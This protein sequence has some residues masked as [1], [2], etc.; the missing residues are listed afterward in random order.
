MAQRWLNLN[1][2]PWGGHHILKG[3]YKESELTNDHKSKLCGT[4]TTGIILQ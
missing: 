1:K 4:F 3:Q 2:I